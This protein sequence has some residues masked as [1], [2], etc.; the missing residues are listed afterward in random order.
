MSKQSIIAVAGLAGVGKTN[1]INRQLIQA[2]DS[3]CYYCPKTDPTP[4]DSALLVSN[5]P[6]LQVITDEQLD[7]LQSTNS[8]IYIELGFH[9]S[10]E[11]A[12]SLLSG[13]NVQKIAIVTPGTVHLDTEWHKWADR[14]EVGQTVSAVEPK[15]L[16]R[17]PLTSQVI[18]PA[19]LD[20]FWDELIKG[21]Y[22]SVQRAKGI[23]DVADGR[24]FYFDFVDGHKNRYQELLLPLWLDGRPHRFSGME[25]IGVN[26]DRQSIGDTLGECCLSDEAI[27]Y[28]Q[29]KTKENMLEPAQ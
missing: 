11:T 24:C 27:A 6:H 19:S 14:V 22:G 23:F 10:L 4:I 3:C 26:L 29:A 21:A 15:D 25:V 13:L 7:Q 2:S 18:D 16:W 9:L 1:W 5:F 8:N 12:K 17:S 20:L 28:Y